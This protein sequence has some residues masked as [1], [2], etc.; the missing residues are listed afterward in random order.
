VSARITFGKSCGILLGIALRTVT[1]LAIR[2]RTREFGR[3]RE[4]T[5]ESGRRRETTRESG[6]RRETTREHHDERTIDDTTAR[7]RFGRG[8][9]GYRESLAAAVRSL[10]AE[11]TRRT[12]EC[13][14]SG[15]PNLRTTTALLPR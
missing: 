15:G 5:R 6:R 12:V 14:L 9:R 2:T 11:V 4:T 7:R 1:T 10:V 8:S 3:R 13:E